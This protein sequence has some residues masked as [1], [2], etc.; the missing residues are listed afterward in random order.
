MT[1]GEAFAFA[2]AFNTADNNIAVMSR[3]VDGSLGAAT[4]YPTGLSRISAH[5]LARNDQYLLVASDLDDLI[6]SY[7]I[8]PTTG[9]LTEVDSEPLPDADRVNDVI[10]LKR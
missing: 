5:C 1:V 10:S 3:S 9:A 8:D 6:I 4:V 7:A 2:F